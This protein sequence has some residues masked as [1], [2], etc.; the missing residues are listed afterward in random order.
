MSVFIVFIYNMWIELGR[1]IDDSKGQ[2]SVGKSADAC[3]ER[4]PMCFLFLSS[5]F[6]FISLKISRT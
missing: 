6:S 2:N 5:I 1:L 4:V 3:S